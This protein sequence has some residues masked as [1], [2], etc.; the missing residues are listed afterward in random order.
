MPI[1][2]TYNYLE[3]LANSAKLECSSCKSRTFLVY[4][5]CGCHHLCEQ[6][7]INNKKCALGHQ[8]DK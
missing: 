6:C 7:A 2:K 5:S 4:L 3:Q 8:Y 1:V